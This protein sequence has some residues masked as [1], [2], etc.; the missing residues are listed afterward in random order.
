MAEINP[1]ILI[2]LH[3]NLPTVLDSIFCERPVVI[4]NNT[5]MTQADYDA[6]VRRPACCGTIDT[7]E[8]GKK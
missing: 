2:Q 5:K 7:R 8:V 6:A 1:L 4:K 3:E